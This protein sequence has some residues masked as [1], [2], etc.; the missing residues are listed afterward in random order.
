MNQ[1]RVS[2]V[3]LGCKVNQCD[4]GA[5][6]AVL[7]QAGICVAGPGDPVDFF[8]VNTCSVTQKANAESRQI[9][10]R[11]KAANPQARILVTGCYASTAAAEI[12]QLPQVDSV[13]GIGRDQE[14]LSA[15]ARLAGIEVRSR[16][17]SAAEHL[18]PKAATDGHSRAFLKVQEG[19]D[20]G[21]SFCIVPRAR[22][23]TRSAPASEVVAAIE[24]LANRGFEEVVLCGPNLGGWGRE[25][26]PPH[27]LADLIELIAERSPLPRVR[28]SSINPNE[29]SPR[30]MNAVTRNSILC[31]HLHIPVQ[32][33]DDR[34]LGL[35]RRRHDCHQVKELF[36]TLTEHVAGVSI[37]TDVIVGFP[38]EDESSFARTRRFLEAL[39]VSYLHVFP[40]SPRNGT[41]AARF[42][43]RPA[44]G[45]VRARVREL[46]ALGRALRRRYAARFLGQMVE[47][48][49]ET[50]RD[51]A[52]GMLRGYT[53]HYVRAL[54]AGSDAL[55]NQRVLIQARELIGTSLLGTAA[56]DE[57]T[58]RA[59]G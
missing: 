28:L 20:L 2:F 53:P 16:P 31:P 56:G 5:L 7:S 43:E 42:R 12:E 58:R 4:S 50:K 54:F 39:P 34:I 26:Q 44:G 22:G 40:F 45:L 46:S 33:G 35:M 6:S 11:L 24:E 29:F 3:T 36:D 30:L 17:A 10:R 59:S 38:G 49:V 25:Q 51:R 32:S 55:M 15:V 47:V 23:R 8:V 21:C 41:P 13:V 19:C 57:G 9:I 52:T 18:S 48:L 14:L 37:G 27:E 1:L